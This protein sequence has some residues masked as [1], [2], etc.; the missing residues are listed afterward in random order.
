MLNYWLFS[1]LYLTVIVGITGFNLFCQMLI[2]NLYLCDPVKE[3]PP[4]LQKCV[5]C[6]NGVCCRRSHKFQSTKE[7]FPEDAKEDVKLDDTASVQAIK[8]D[9][10]VILDEQFMK[11]VRLL[12]EKMESE[13]KHEEWRDAWK[14]LARLLDMMFFIITFIAHATMI[15]IYFVFVA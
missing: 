14:N 3:M 6:L 13:N 15:I 7:Q 12:L 5:S 4:W 10:Q 9:N 8:P 2:M 11:A 1:G